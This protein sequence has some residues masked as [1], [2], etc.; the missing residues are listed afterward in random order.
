MP[1]TFFLRA[2]GALG[3]LFPVASFAQV[4]ITGAP[5]TQNFDSL[6]N[7]G[8]TN[9]T[10]P[11]GWF[12]SEPGSN[13]QYIASNGSGVGLSGS[14]YSFG[15]TGSGERALGSIA[16]GTTAPTIG[17]QLRNDTGSTLSTLRVAFT[18]E[19]W[20]LGTPGAADRL[21]FAYSTDATSLTTGTWTP[22]SALDAVSKVT[23]GTV[24][25]ALDG[26]AAANR[27]AVTFDIASL[28]VASNATIWI[29]WSD[30]NDANVDD[31]IGIDDVSLGLPGDIPP[32]FLSSVPQHNAAN[33]AIDTPISVTFSESVDVAGDWFALNGCG[34]VTLTPSAGPASTYTFTRSGPLP[35]GAHCTLAIDGSLVTDRDG[36]IQPMAGVEQIAFD[37]VADELPVVTATTPADVATGVVRSANLS[38]TFSEPVTAPASA[39]GIFCP[40]TAPGSLA[41]ALSSEDNLLFVLDPNADLPAS[42][43]C[44]LTVDNLQ[45]TDQDGTPDAPDRDTAIFFDTAAVAPPA[46]VTTVPAK[47]STNFPPAGDLQIVFDHSVSLS[48]GAFVLNC[49]QSAGI[50][51]TH[52]VTGSSFAVDTGTTLTAGD[53]CTLTIEADAVVSGDN[54]H[55]VADEIVMFQVASSGAGNY[56]SGVDTSSCTALRTSLHNLIKD[57]TAVS[58][59]GSAPN[60][61]TVIN[62]ADEDPLNTANILDVYK[63]NSC[64]KQLSGATCYNKE[65]TWPNSRGFNDLE[66]L[67]GQPY[68]PYTDVHMLYASDVGF[69]SHRGNLNYGN[70]TSGCSRDDTNFYFN[71]GGGDDDNLYN[72]SVYEVWDHRKGDAAR[73]VLYMDVRYEGGTNANGQ[74]EPDLIV[75]DNLALVTATPSGVPQTHG[76][77]GVRSDIIAWATADPPDQLEML[78]NDAV[79]SYQNNR[80]PFIDHPEWVECVFNCNCGAVGNNPPVAN[81]TTFALAENASPSTV[82]GTVVATDPDAGASLTYSIT[83]GN[84]SGAFSMSGNQLRVANAAP[85]NFETTPQFVLTVTVSDG[86]LSD[87]AQITVNLNNVN[88]AP[89]ASDATYSVAENIIPPALVGPVVASDPDA[90]A[91][92]TYTITGGNGSGAFTMSGNQVAVA[93]GASLDFETTPQYVLTVTV[94][95]GSLSDTATITVNL[96]NVNEA[97]VANDAIFGLVENSP[98]ATVVGQVAASDVDA[99]STLT[100]SITGGNASG[101]FAISS[102]GQ[103]TVANASPLNFE[104]TPQFVLTVTVSDGSLNDTATITINLGNVDEGG[105]V[106]NDD[107]ATV[108]EDS[109]NNAI[110]VLGNDVADPDGGAL[111]VT[112]AGA[113]Q[114]GSTSFTATGVSYTPTANYCGA[115]SFNYTLNGGDIAAVNVTVSCSNDAP[116]TAATLPARSGNEGEPIATFSIATGFSDVDGDDLDYGQTGLPAGLT[117]DAETGEIGGVPATGSAAASPYTVVITASDGTLSVQQSFQFTLGVRAATVFRHGFEGN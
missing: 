19:Q 31:G 53:S 92:L 94:S 91:T 38:V 72:A 80:N 47:S 83:A 113:A 57:H 104:T 79:Y 52:A 18:M 68:P 117:L 93:N 9:T 112:A 36:T 25:T 89:V 62:L 64:L 88:E 107:A 76:Y 100:H 50:N 46:I 58:Y 84:A 108:A 10:L 114:H 60:A 71:F 48:A 67:N 74:A 37:V 105:E 40:D 14:V 101:A 61:L 39:F 102:G 87:T 55:P 12:L 51:L 81:D 43:H 29:R 90:G 24:D 13:G 85:L 77:I 109:S 111:A 45:V 28:S 8:T 110:A 95:D 96:T 6:A 70:C 103:I 78:R 26:N 5:A 35:F 106:A 49:V 86:S 41:F 34:G 7:T 98:T 1:K 44:K 4:S 23:I 33:V 115:D 116:A 54:L 15:S 65:H 75:T 66:S 59:S 97:P 11:A 30:I 56:Y 32:A 2:L 99:G 16:S 73:A 21:T 3:L 20:K 22:V 82:V 42:T 63:N 69:N 27:T 17:A